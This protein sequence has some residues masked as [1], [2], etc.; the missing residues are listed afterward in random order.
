MF[1]KQLDQFML[2]YLYYFK[3]ENIAKQQKCRELWQ[4]TWRHRLQLGLDCDVR[5]FPIQL[6]YNPWYYFA[7][8]NTHNYCNWNWP[9]QVLCLQIQMNYFTTSK[10]DNNNV[11]WLVHLVFCYIIKMLLPKAKKSKINWLVAML[12]TL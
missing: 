3:V 11:G 8:N 6:F 10:N 7:I 12:P 4:Y 5:K 2:Q 1:L 9:F